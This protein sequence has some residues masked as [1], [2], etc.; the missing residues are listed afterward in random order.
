MKTVIANPP[1]SAKWSA[2]ISFMD[3][4]RFSKAG[5]LAPKSK[6]DY[7]FIMDIVHKLDATGIAA[8]VLPHG[9]LFRGS[10]EGV[11]RQFLIEKKNYIDAIIGLPANI[12]YGTSIP[13]CILV[14]KKCRKEDDNI[15]FIDASKEFEKLRNRNSLTDVQIDKI[16]RTFQERK[17]IEKYSHCATL[18]EIRDNNYNLNLPRYIDVFE[19][20]EPIDIKA[21]MAEIKELEA[22]RAE[23]D[24]EIDVYLR[25]L[26]LI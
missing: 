23:L 20:E 11:I 8:I 10:S 18:Q 16:V 14:I 17:E 3:D 6:A 12:F 1:F 22:E 25:E 21:V 2:D 4:E 19:E 9:V 5:K 7:A 13:T 15:L 26:K 24:K